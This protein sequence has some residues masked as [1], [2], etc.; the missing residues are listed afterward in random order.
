MK[1]ND[2]NWLGQPSGPASD[3]SINRRAVMPAALGN[4][5]QPGIASELQ[6]EH[7]TITAQLTPM[8]DQGQL[9]KSRPIEVSHFDGRD[10]SFHHPLPLASRRAFVSIED[11]RL[12][13]WEALVELGWCRFNR[14]GN[15]TSGGRFV[16]P[17]ARSA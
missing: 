9:G 3:L 8:N 15:Y 5:I 7:Q 17:S 1:P 2:G 4:F 12:G 10:I 16:R 11:E 6:D 13:S 14:M